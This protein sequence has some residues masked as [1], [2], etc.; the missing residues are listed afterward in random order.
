[1][2][3]IRQSVIFLCEK[4]DCNTMIMSDSSYLS[5]LEYQ[6]DEIIM[7]NGVVFNIKYP[8]TVADNYRYRVQWA[9]TPPLVIMVVL[10]P[11]SVL[12]VHGEQTGFPSKFLLSS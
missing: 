4:P 2:Y 1:M 8:K 10:C 5:V 12:R 9:I 11:K 3:G 6:K 7:F